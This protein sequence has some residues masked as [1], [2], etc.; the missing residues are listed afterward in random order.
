MASLTKPIAESYWVI[1]GRLLAGKYPGGKN[2]QEVERRLGALLDGGFN[3]FID[4]TDVGEMPPY[5]N[6]LPEAVAYV[7]KP[8]TDHG[9]P[10]DAAYMAEILGERS[11]EHTSELQSPDH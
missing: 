7:R 1:P 11:E 4:L 6:Y 2:L 10:P 3:G 9:V 8:I 5:D